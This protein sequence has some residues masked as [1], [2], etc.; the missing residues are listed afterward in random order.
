MARAQE[1]DRRGRPGG[2]GLYGLSSLCQLL[3]QILHPT[4]VPVPC[5]T[6][7]GASFRWDSSAPG[8]GTGQ[9]CV[10]GWCCLQS[11]SRCRVAVA[12]QPWLGDMP[13]G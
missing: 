12:F 2:T 8:C 11:M 13:H 7:V 4:L 5:F 1:Y 9:Q 3:A 10:A 6:E